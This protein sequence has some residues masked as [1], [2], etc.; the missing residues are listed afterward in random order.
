MIRIALLGATGSI[1]RS[2]LELVARHPDRFEIVGVTAHRSTAALAEI[3]SRLRPRRAVVA[4]PSA[5]SAAGLAGRRGD[6]EWRGGADAVCELAADADG[7]VVVNAMLGAAGLEPTL[8]AL[9]AGH[10]LALA[11]KESLVAGGPLVM[12]AMRRGGGSLIP[13]D[14]EHSAILQCIAGS[15]TRAVHRVVLTASGGP[16]R[17]WTVEQLAQ[18]GPEAALRHPT[19]DMGAKISIDSATLANKALEVIEAHFLYGLDYDHI[20]AVVHPQSI[21]HSFVE[22]VD[23]SV[24][25]QVGT[26]TMELP[27]LYA[28]THPERVADPV[29]RTF[30]PVASSPLSFAPIDH[31][32]FPLFGLGID[33]GRRGG[34]APAAFNAGN[35]IAVSAFLEGRVS[36][37]A[38]AEVVSA[39]L[40]AVGEDRPGSVDDVRRADREARA[41]ARARL[42]RLEGSL[43]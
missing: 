32:A 29:L 28:L 4:D 12:E 19:W 13:V 27:I 9:G 35:E 3:V 39:A 24:L 21:V 20:D 1:G 43:A 7:D 15:P 33:A 22:F 16:F 25:A 17:D 2:T 11:N 26:P 6:T 5:L 14:S 18:V 30:D 10:R 8:A 31:E 37:P 42:A 23:G 38:M 36:F 34:L 40:V 41:A